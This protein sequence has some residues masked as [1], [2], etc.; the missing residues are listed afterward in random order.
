M[1]VNN[2]L[3][4]E[5]YIIFQHLLS[6]LPGVSGTYMRRLFYKLLLK[7]CGKGFRSGTSVKIQTPSSVSVGDNVGL[8][9]RVW[10]A[11]NKNSNGNIV[12]GN[13]VIVG[14]NT[15]IH[16]G[17]HRYDRLDIPIRLQGYKFSPIVIEDDVWIAAG[18]II[19]AG[20][21]IGTGSVIAAGSVVVHNVDPFT[22][23]GG[24]P[25]KIISKRN[26]Y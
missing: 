4:I 9:D 3:V 25:A 2:R 20:V 18:V 11:A 15:I 5:V 12:I 17:N 22:V 24:I 8:N 10:I 14:P 1:K 7:K 26:E 23:V 6:M 13:N 16:S 19:L 21:R